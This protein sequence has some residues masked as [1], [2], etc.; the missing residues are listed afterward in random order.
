MSIIISIIAACTAK[1]LVSS[2]DYYSIEFQVTGASISSN[3]RKHRNNVKQ[4]RYEICGIL[5]LHENLV[6]VTRPKQIP[7]GMKLHVN[8]YIAKTQ[9]IDLNPEKKI[10]DANDSG[11]LS[12]VIKD[13]WN[14]SQ[15]PTVSNIKYQQH[16]SKNRVKNSVNIRVQSV[17]QN[18]ENNTKMQQKINSIEMEPL[19][20]E[21]LPVI[22]TDRGSG[23]KDLDDDSDEM[24][25]RDVN[26]DQQGH[27][28]QMIDNDDYIIKSINETHMNEGIN[29]VYGEQDN[30]AV[31]AMTPQ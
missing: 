15:V 24:I 16:E 28:L 11:Q 27:Q 3:F 7:N 18:T 2:Q 31:E 4:I 10:G 12:K 6:E 8:I 21:V 25:T 5:G 23:E 9:A 26:T 22:A 19:P 1:K 30:D 13:A 29:V 17:S 20:A 14:L